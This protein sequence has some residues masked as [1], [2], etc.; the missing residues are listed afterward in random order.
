MC[1]APS[2][3]EQWKTSLEI[4]GKDLA[5][6]HTQPGLTIFLLLMLLEWK[7][8]TPRKAPIKMEHDLHELQ[9]AQDD[10]G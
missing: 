4:L 1:T 5:K 9:N 7:K 3:I 10:I 2:T 6:C 8:R